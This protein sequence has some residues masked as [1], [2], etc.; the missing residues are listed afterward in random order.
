LKVFPDGWDSE[1]VYVTRSPYRLI[2]I[3]KSNTGAATNSSE[4]ACKPKSKYMASFKKLQAHAEHQELLIQQTK[5]NITLEHEQHRVLADGI[6]QQKVLYELVIPLHHE[7]MQQPVAE[8]CTS[9]QWLRSCADGV[10]RP[11]GSGWD[12]LVSL[13]ASCNNMLAA[14]LQVGRVYGGAYGVDSCRL[15]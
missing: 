14:I 6:C 4:A 3:M 5:D 12:T 7:W 8:D 2:L 1:Y 15:S 11:P 10:V 9:S 13:V